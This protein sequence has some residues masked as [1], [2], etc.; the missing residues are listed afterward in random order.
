MYRL[1]FLSLAQ[2]DVKKLSASGLKP[3]VSQLLELIQL[4]SLV[5]PEQALTQ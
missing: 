5:D 3:I 2:K 4:D 1:V